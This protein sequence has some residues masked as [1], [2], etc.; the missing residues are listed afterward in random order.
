MVT[1]SKGRPSKFK[2]EYIVQA[3]KL[4][5]LGLK[6]SEMASV[7][8]VCEKTFNNWKI[9]FPDFLQ[10]LKEGKE[11]ADANVTERLYQRAMGF[12]HKSEKV[13]NYQGVIVR[14][15]TV[16]IYPPDTAAC[17]FWLKNRQSDK[18]RDKREADA[19]S[20]LGETLRELANKLPD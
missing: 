16:E 5:L 10:S 20:D 17:I 19:P 18:W 13:F 15:K 8:G 12:E 4:A 7:F 9:D 6:D 3:R 2:D 1:K 11:F 14:A